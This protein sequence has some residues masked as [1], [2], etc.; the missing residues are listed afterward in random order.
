[1]GQCQ[2]MIAGSLLALQRW[3][4]EVML[5]ITA[6]PTCAGNLMY[7]KLRRTA[8]WDHLERWLAGLN[9]HKT[10]AAVAAAHAP[11]GRAAVAEEKTA[12]GR[13]GGGEQHWQ[14]WHVGGSVIHMISCCMVYYMLGHLVS[15]GS[16]N[17]LGPFLTM[18]MVWH[19]WQCKSLV[20]MSNHVACMTLQPVDQCGTSG[21]ALAC[22]V[23]ADTG[24]FVGLKDAVK[25][26]VVTR[27][28]PEPSGR[29]KK[30]SVSHRTAGMMPLCTM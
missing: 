14:L 29:R 18:Q 7:A 1:M 17:C 26:K 2:A 16:V 3:H 19:R 9:G 27:F 21:S 5:S 4:P 12:S 11:K 10:L 23:Y 13:G 28:P 24:S 25:G 6:G 20:C 8:G 30:C 22:C 15:V